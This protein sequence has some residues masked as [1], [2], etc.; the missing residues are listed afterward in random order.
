M[1]RRFEMPWRPAYEAW[2]AA[3]WLGAMMALTVT[4]L[5][6]DMPRGP[7]W[8]MM[9]AAGV[10]FLVNIGNAWRIWSVKFSLSGVGIEKIK[11]TV[12]KKLQQKHPQNLWIGYGFDWKT[13]HTQRVYEM[14][15]RDPSDFYP[16]D[17]FLKVRGLITGKT[18]G[19]LNKDGVG[20]PWIHGVEPKEQQLSMPF[21]NLIGNTLIVGTTRCGKTRMLDVL[22][23]Q[24]IHQPN[25]AVISIDPKGDA[26]LEANMRRAA[27]AAGR[28]KD[29]VSLHLAFPSRSIRI[30]SMKNYNNV[31]E[32]AS[33]LSALIQSDGGTGDAFAAFAWDVA[34]AICL[35]LI[36]IN[37]KPTILKVRQYVEGGVEPLLTKCLPAFFQQHSGTIKDWEKKAREYISRGMKKNPDG[38]MPARDANPKEVLN[39]YLMMYKQVYKEAGR[40]LRSEAI[41]ALANIYEHDVTHYGKM[42]A[43]FKPVLTMLTTGE[44]AGLLSPDPDDIDD[45]RLCTDFMSLINSQSIVYIGLNALADKTVA[46]AVGAMFLS[47]LAACAAARYNFG[48]EEDKKRI[49]YLCV[50]EAAQV[51]NEPYIQVLNMAGGSGFA[52]VA[53]TQTIPD[54]TARLGSEDKARVMLGNFNNLFALRSKDRVTQDFITETFGKSYVYSMQRSHGTNSST[55]KNITHFGGTISEKV[56]DS[57][58]EIFPPDLLGMLPNW[59]YMGS[60]LGGRKVKGRV[61]ILTA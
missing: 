54:F 22:T 10:F 39:G 26:E 12:L 11:I 17:I 46:S 45:D 37:D 40:A 8:Y 33:R 52:N 35:G 43:N 58:E 44:L 14:K 42:V 3:G 32:L 55:E 36:A 38:S 16:P 49:V 13:V 59:Q 57:L 15:K 47:D 51:V 6:S 31:S 53:A 61:P 27:K 9:L 5:A 25:A 4:V 30:D 34:N 29:F 20:A 48:T 7:Y 23:G 19:A 60:I 24:F 21:D 41:D 1:M 18:V 56:S 50:D 2:A 28:E